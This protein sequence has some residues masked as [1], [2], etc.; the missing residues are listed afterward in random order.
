MDWLHG[1]WKH[2]SKFEPKKIKQLGITVQKELNVDCMGDAWFY[3][4]T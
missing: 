1:F 3:R 2:A 4:I